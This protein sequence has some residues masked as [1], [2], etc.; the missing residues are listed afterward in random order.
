L[1]LKND[2]NE[3]FD[4]RF[5]LSKERTKQDN[6]KTDFDKAIKEIETNNT[7]KYEE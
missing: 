6:L 4:L 3:I 1:V 5:E 7:M 2:D